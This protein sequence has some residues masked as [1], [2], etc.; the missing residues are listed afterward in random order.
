MSQK[1]DD[2]F[3]Q[4]LD[5]ARERQRA[6][7]IPMV[8]EGFPCKV[9]PLSWATFIASG[10]M[11]GRLTDVMLAEPGEAQGAPPDFTKDEV[12]EGEAFRR[13]AVCRVLAE[14]RII[15]E[16]QPGEGEYLYADLLETAPAFISAVFR[17]ILAG[18]PK[19]KGEE[20][21]GLSADDLERFPE[22]AG[23]GAGARGGDNVKSEQQKPKRVGGRNRKR[24][25]RP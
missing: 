7:A 10:R 16:G 11:P 9:I 25:S 3:Q 6:Q 15:A 19:P 17:W 13:T 2:V 14:P 18:C 20:A 8:F 12:I 21:E 5:E 24:T 22:G 4:K 23:E 1:I